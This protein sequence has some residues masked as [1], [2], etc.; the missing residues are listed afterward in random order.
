M[1]TSGETPVCHLV[2]ITKNRYKIVVLS[3]KFTSYHAEKIPG[4][5]FSG[6]VESWVFPVSE[7]NRDIFESIIQH[8]KVEASG[9]A[10]TNLR[11]IIEIDKFR[12]YLE[13]ERYSESTVNTYVSFLTKFFD[14]FPNKSPD[15][16]GMEEIEIYNYK[17]IIRKGL[18][19]S[20]QNQFV[21]AIKKFYE[22]IHRNTII[23]DNIERPRKEK[24]LPQVLSKE[25]VS[26]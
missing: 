9:T 26:L 17:F 10:K 25:D 22:K 2:Y 5:Y 11:A 12:K 7:K 3:G 8:H 18:S 23:I 15:E 1:K 14:F 16:I 24:R 6:N 4:C 19:G 21:S 20:F 13:N